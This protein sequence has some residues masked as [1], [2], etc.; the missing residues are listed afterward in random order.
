MKK[1]TERIRVNKKGRKDAMERTKER[2]SKEGKKL[3]K[4]MRK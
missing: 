4:N 2:D 3:G 1:V